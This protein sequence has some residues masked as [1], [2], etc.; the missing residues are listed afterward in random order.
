MQATFYV[1]LLPTYRGDK[2]VGA[3]VVKLTQNLPTQSSN[4]PVGSVFVKIELDVDKE[5]FDPLAVGLH[6]KGRQGDVT[7]TVSPKDGVVEIARQL[8]KDK[9]V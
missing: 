2:V 4:I 9:G 3:R 6:V 1:Q 8:T 7:A 5:V